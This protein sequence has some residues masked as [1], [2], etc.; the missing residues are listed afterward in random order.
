MR[1]RESRHERRQ[2]SD[3]H[4]RLHE[5]TIHHGITLVPS[6]D[7]VLSA[8]D[9]SIAKPIKNGSG[10]SS[11][12][13]QQLELLLVDP[14]LGH[15]KVQIADHVLV[16]S[17]LDLI[18]HRRGRAA[19]R[20]QRPRRRAEVAVA[21]LHDAGELLAK[22]GIRPRALVVTP[23]L[24]VADHRVPAAGRVLD[25]ELLALE[26]QRAL[27]KIGNAQPEREHRGVV[28]VRGRACVDR[29]EHHEPIS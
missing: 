12:R 13:H 14:A 4:E 2:R 21:G 27:G 15:R 8:H 5:P 9:Q 17:D 10:Y 1:L 25:D 23:V 28:H 11:A 24:V 7:G 26:G 6:G 19:R 20:E 3:R 18:D 22:L 16:A 29:Q